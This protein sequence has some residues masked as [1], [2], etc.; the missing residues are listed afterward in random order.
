[1]HHCRYFCIRKAGYVHLKGFEN[2]SN[3]ILC[4]KQG[5]FVP[6]FLFHKMK[7]DGHALIMWNIGIV[8]RKVHQQNIAFVCAVL[9][10][11]TM[12]ALFKLPA[13]ERH[14]LSLLGSSI[15][16]NKVLCRCRC[17]YFIT[18]NVINGFVYHDIAGDIAQVS[19]L[20]DWELIPRTGFIL[21]GL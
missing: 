7:Q 1:M 16:V 5:H 15:V 14:A 3:K 19:A 2:L 13:V 12:Q 4:D 17:Q 6:D 21:S 11:I 20:I 10:V 8:A 9:H 18:K